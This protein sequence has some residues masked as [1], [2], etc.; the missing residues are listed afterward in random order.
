MD[1]PRRHWQSTLLRVVF[2]VYSGAK[3]NIV[4]CIISLLDFNRL[5]I[6]YELSLT[7]LETPLCA[8]SICVITLDISTCCCL[9]S[10][11]FL[12]SFHRFFNN[13][14]Y[15]AYLENAVSFNRKLNEERKMRLPFV[16][17][18]TGVAQRHYNTG[19]KI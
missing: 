19:I 15:K 10:Y 9:S 1:Q 3:T 8:T 17:S 4:S 6:H 5:N 16:D 18:Q 7:L 11:W 2:F 13:P 12:T 14:G